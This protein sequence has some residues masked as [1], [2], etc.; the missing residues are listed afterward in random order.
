MKR[1]EDCERLMKEGERGKGIEIE[2]R[3]NEGEEGK[4]K[5]AKRKTV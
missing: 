2:E 1:E 4:G 3:G 5:A